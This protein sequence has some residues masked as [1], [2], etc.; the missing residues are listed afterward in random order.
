MGGQIAFADPKR[1]LAAAFVRS[2]LTS[3][4]VFSERL[5]DVLYACTLNG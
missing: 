2:Q 1:S 4:H 5:L 3:A